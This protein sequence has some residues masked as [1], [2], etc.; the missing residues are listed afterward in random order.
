MYC[1]EFNN[2]FIKQ[3]SHKNDSTSNQTIQTIKL[4]NM[5]TSNA[6]PHRNFC[7]FQPSA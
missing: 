7:L 3:Q 2:N 6:N 1:D 5:Y 4:K